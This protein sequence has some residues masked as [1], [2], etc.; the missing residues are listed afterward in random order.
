[1]PTLLQA[2][3]RSV[4]AGAVTFLPSTVRFTSAISVAPAS[5]RLWRARLALA[6]CHHHETL[7]AFA[8]KLAGETPALRVHRKLLDHAFLLVRARPAFQVLFELSAELLYECDRRHCCR[9]AQRAECP[10][11]HV[12]R[13]VLHVVDV[14]LQTAASMEPDQSLLQP[15]RPFAAGDAPPAAFMLI[16]LHG[17][18]REFHDAL[19][20]INDDHAA[21]SQHR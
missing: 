19:R 11:Q 18:Q 10:S 13:E 16:K 7:R 2:S 20:V 5:R 8:R 15:V 21:R 1:M 4:P 14:L 17:P 6:P 12:L 3:M 9:I